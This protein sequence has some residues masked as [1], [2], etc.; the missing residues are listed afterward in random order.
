MFTGSGNVPYGLHD[1]LTEGVG[2]SNNGTTNNDRTTY[3]ETVP[4][5]YLES[6]LWLEADRMGFL[7]DS[8][9]LAKLERAARHR[10]E[11]APPGRGQ[12]AL[13]PRRR[14][15]RAGDLSRD[16]SLFVG[17][18]RQHG[19]SVRGLGR[20]RQGLLPPL[21]RAE[22]R[23]SSPSSATSIPAQAKAWVTKYFGGIPARQADHAPRGRAGDA[24]RRDAAG[25]RGSRAGAAT[26][27]PVA[28]GRREERRPLRA[29]RARRRSCPAR[30]PRGSPRRSST[31]SSGGVGVGV[32]STNEDVG[33]FLV[34]DHAAARPH[35]DELERRATRSS[36]KMKADGPTAEEIQ[37]A[38]AGEEL[39]V[40]QRPRVESRQGHASCP[41]A[42]AIHGDP[43]ISGPSSPEEARR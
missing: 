23:L 38:T 14:D 21:L 39:D 43:G 28:D 30:A 25:V 1:K 29:R 19:G 22:Q 18:D 40:R 4:T 35:A 24:R 3:Y 16:A 31:T 36:S 15:S 34:V 11:R 20:G 13:R 5:N 27:H 32:Q 26:L 12:P 37:K 6:A 2:G 41:T 10:E 7:L 42:P 17:R 33:D 8:L 9:D